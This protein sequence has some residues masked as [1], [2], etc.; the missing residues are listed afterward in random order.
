M[1]I[2]KLSFADGGCFLFGDTESQNKII[3]TKWLRN[4]YQ[5]TDLTNYILTWYH[6]VPGIVRYYLHP[7]I[8][9]Y[10][11]IQIRYYLHPRYQI[12]SNVMR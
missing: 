3:R 9:R 10:T 5:E 6:S 2:L 12:T 4:R 8:Y 7:L 11:D 1:E